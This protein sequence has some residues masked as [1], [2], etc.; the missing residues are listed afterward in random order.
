MVEARH[1]SL[2][3]EVGGSTANGV[4]RTLRILWYFY[5]ERVPDLPPN[6]VKRLKRQ[7]FAEPRRKRMIPPEKMPEFY[8]AVRML[9]NKITRDLLLLL[10]FTGFRKAEASPLRW[11]NINLQKP[12]TPIPPQKTN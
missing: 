6:P 3:A 8:R 7:W 1:R 5:A 10:A 12:T 11:E 2:A 9:D 4:M